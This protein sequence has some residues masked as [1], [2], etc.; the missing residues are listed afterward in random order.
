MCHKTKKLKQNPN[1]YYHIYQQAGLNTSS[2]FK[3]STAALLILDKPIIWGSRK[4]D[5]PV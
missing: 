4:Q 3:W 2:L 5:A 1:L